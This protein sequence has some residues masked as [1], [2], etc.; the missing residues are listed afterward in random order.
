MRASGV[1][2]EI[3]RRDMREFARLAET[4]YDPAVVDRVLD[5]LGDMWADAWLAVRTTTHP[6]PVR[7]VSA[8]FMNLP[9]AADPVGR[10]RAAGLLEFVG[11]PMEELL[12][13]VSAAV[14]V[15]WGVDLAVDRGV[16]KIWTA[17]PDLISVDRIVSFAGMPNSARAHAELLKRWGGGGIALM[18]VDFVN[19][20][21]NLYT[22]ILAPGQLTA[23]GIAT[24]LREL[25]FVAADEGE[26]AAV[27]WPFTVY[28]TFDWT[29]P[30]IQRICFPARYTAES[31]PPIDPVL[32]RFVEGAPFAGPGPRGFAFYAAYGPTGRYYKVQADYT[33][34]AR[35]TLPGGVGV[36]QSR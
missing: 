22:Q 8:R 14:P 1:T 24:I 10:L 6:A 32:S 16:Q 13:R 18:A 5:A 21:L 34:A 15:D 2:A 35:Q 17:F 33:S 19:R 28:A 27:G 31:F 9:A 11:H 4:R 7:Q 36:P 20:T 26:L 30:S 12:A 29:A 3:F 23:A 25:D